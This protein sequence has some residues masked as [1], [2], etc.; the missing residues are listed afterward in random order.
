MPLK[1]RSSDSRAIWRT[2]PRNRRRMSVLQERS[3]GAAVRLADKQ[4]AERTEYPHLVLRR[5]RVLDKGDF[6][7]SEAERMLVFVCCNRRRS[8]LGLSSRAVESADVKSAVA[9]S[10]KYRGLGVEQG[11]Q[12]SKYNSSTLNRALMQKMRDDQSSGDKAQDKTTAVWS[13][14]CEGA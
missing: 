1:A 11:L 7:A 8:K 4:C 6:H 13:E 5:R 12:S 3:R 9:L 10:R 2:R 14:E